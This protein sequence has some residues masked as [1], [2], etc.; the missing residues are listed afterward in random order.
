LALRHA[1]AVEGSS[2]LLPALPLG[3][4]MRWPAVLVVCWLWWQQALYVA[5]C[6]P[7]LAGAVHIAPTAQGHSL[8]AYAS[9]PPR[10]VHPACPPGAPS[11]CVNAAGRLHPTPACRLSAKTASTNSS[12]SCSGSGRCGA[13]FGRAGEQ[14]VIAAA[15]PH[16]SPLGYGSSGTMNAQLTAWAPAPH[17]Q[18]HLNPKV[19]DCPFVVDLSLPEPAGTSGA[20]SG[21]AAADAAKAQQQQAALPGTA[22]QA[23]A[24]GALN[25]PMTGNVYSLDSQSLIVP[26]IKGEDGTMRVLVRACAAWLAHLSISPRQSC[27][28]HLYGMCWPTATVAASVG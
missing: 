22:A 21:A 8:R 10:G 5:V 7:G 18:I 19:I 11:F 20:D 16:N 14:A 6:L 28:P 2:P 27:L 12:C 13:G 15:M 1:L 24:P 3:C 26:L 4:R 17:L 25:T 23:G 9:G